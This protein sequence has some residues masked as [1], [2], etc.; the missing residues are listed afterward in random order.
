MKEMKKTRFNMWQNTGF[1][2]RNAWQTRKSVIFLCIAVAVITAAHS[3]V[4]L[5]IAPSILRHVENADPLNRLL[6]SIAGFSIL[7]ILL[8]SLKAYLN[9]NTLYGRVSVRLAILQQIS[10]KVSRTS[11]PN[12][13]NADFLGLEEKSYQACSTNVSPTEAVWNTWTGILTDLFGFLVYLTLLSG[14]NPLLILFISAISIAAFFVNSRIS[15][16]AYRHRDE[17]AESF[18]QMDYIRN[19]AEQRPAAKDIRI[20]GLRPWLTQVW[21]SAMRVYRSFLNRRER[22]D[23]W[24]DITALLLTLLR[25][26]AAYA[27]LIHQTLTQGLPASEFL[28]YF[29][30]V[31]GFTQW[32]TGILER[33][34]QL[35]RQ[36][37]DLSVIRKFLDYPEPFLF[38]KGK[39]LSGISASS[40]EIRLEDVSFRYPEAAS[41]SLSHISLTLHPGEK[42]AVVG[43]NGAGKTT[44]VRI[45]CGF[46]DPTEGSVLLNGQDIR[47][48]DRHGYYRL[49]SAVF[50]DFSV[51][52]ASVAENVAQRVD[53]I[54][55]SRVQDC[56]EKAGLSEKVAR[57]PRGM[58]T[59]VGRQVFE[60]GVEFSGGETQR[61][62]LARALYKDAPFLI[63]DEPTAALDPIAEN[64]IYMKY[65][66]MTAGKTSLF[67]SHRL[68]ST[69]FCDRILFLQEGRIAEEGTHESL[70]EQNGGYA[71]LFQVQS[72]YYQKDRFSS[73]DA[74]SIDSHEAS[75]AGKEEI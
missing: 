19:I 45:I 13:L 50:Q 37:M 71:G 59:Y 58:D 69:R 2:L 72:R 16:W 40:C 46:L 53:G 21:E 38:E 6:F 4:E 23:L 43:L 8:A 11:Y 3:T 9:T 1:M 61:L 55:R 33:F 34:S 57:L 41:D 44:L 24:T 15:G 54:D 68:A 27:F 48:Y 63:L 7:L 56:L 26:G 67:I 32:V 29:S 70:M 28:L 62:M 31:S 75:A 30:A 17:E 47:Q 65:S 49:F 51:L 25:N 64:D 66:Q 22:N 73:Q 20:F 12:T 5:L 14:L 52:E 35:Q 42:L 36:S 39:P 74:F 18:K 10:L 60:D